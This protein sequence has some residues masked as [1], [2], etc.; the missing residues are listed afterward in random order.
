MQPGPAIAIVFAS[1]YAFDGQ[2]QR[3]G[4]LCVGPPDLWQTDESA[5]LV[6]PGVH[7]L[8]QLAKDEI[9]APL[10]V[11]VQERVTAGIG[12]DGVLHEHFCR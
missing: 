8:T 4:L 3:K 6:A 5:K 11:S 1:K 12:V 2:P 10:Y 9:N 7:A